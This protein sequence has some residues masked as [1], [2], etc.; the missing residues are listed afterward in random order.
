MKTRFSLYMLL[1]SVSIAVAQKPASKPVLDPGT[2]LSDW[3][4]IRDYDISPDGKY[5]WYSYSLSGSNLCITSTDGKSKKDFQG[6]VDN[7]V[8]ISNS[9]LLFPWNDTL[10]I[11][12]PVSGGLE[13]VGKSNGYK[14]AKAGKEEWLA[15]NFSDSL[16]IKNIGGKS[17]SRYGGVAGYYFNPSGTAIVIDKKNSLVWF[18]LAGK[19]EKIIA[20]QTNISSITFDNTGKQ[21]AFMSELRSAQVIF[22]YQ[23]GMDTA[24]IFLQM[25]SKGIPSGNYIS[26]ESPRFSNDG[27]HLYFK[28]E[29]KMARAKKR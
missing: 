13:N 2:I 18:E 11:Y 22:L 28:L 3:A 21:L 19:T 16:F 26:G 12:D 5:A 14:Y 27:L 8:F 15:Y 23:Q 24:R 17:I 4:G 7:P 6:V 29:E 9:R 20:Q 25:G 10:R 1:L